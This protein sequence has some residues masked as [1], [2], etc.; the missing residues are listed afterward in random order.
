MTSVLAY[1]LKSAIV[2]ALF[3]GFYWSFLRKETFFR[4]NRY[5]FIG[6]MISSLFLP[7][8][9][10]GTLLPGNE[11][12]PVRTISESYV[13]FQNT[14]I[15][16]EIYSAP[17]E[18][19]Q[20][21]TW[22]A[23]D[24]LLFV[25]VAGAVVLTLRLLTQVT[26]LA[27]RIRRSDPI[28]IDNIKVILHK[29][30]RSP[31]SFFNYVFVN[32][33]QFN[34][35]DM[36]DVLLHEKE[37]IDQKHGFDL[38]FAEL[39]TILQWPNP[40]AWLTKKSLIETHEY[41]AD[42]A[43]LKKGV[44]VDEYQRTLISFMLGAGNPALIT[45]FNF[46][47][48]KKRLIMMKKIK[49][50]NIRK[51]RSL[52]LLPFVAILLIAFS[53]P[54]MPKTSKQSSPLQK[55][56]TTKAM[57]I[58]EQILYIKDG[59]EISY[60]EMKKIPHDSIARVSVLKGDMAAKYGGKGKDGVIIITTKKNA[61]EHHISG[62]VIDAKTGE[63]KQGV[64]VNAYST[65]S[66]PSVSTKTLLLMSTTHKSDSIRK[67]KLPG[68]LLII[69]DGVEIS[70]EE[71]KNTPHDSIARVEVLKG[72]MAAKY[73]GN[74]KDGVIIITTK[75]NAQEHH[76]SG[77]V[78]D[79]KTGEPKKGVSV[80]VYGTTTG[81]LTDKNGK[82]SLNLENEVSKLSFSFVGY[83]TVTGNFRSGEAPVIKLKRSVTVISFDNLPE[84]QTPVK[85]PR[86]DKSKPVFFVVESMPEYPGGVRALRDYI[87][88]NTRY[89]AK[90][91]KRKTEGTVYVNFTVDETGKVK[92][93]YIDKTKTVD[94][95]LDKEAVRVVSQM[96]DWKP[97]A[98][99]GKNVPV[100][101]SVPVTFNL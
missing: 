75:K 9:N 31:F 53:D 70:N 83:E 79:A 56:D 94:P 30:V 97:G 29:K 54:S 84:P 99:R 6:S 36:G 77:T 44:P 18:K 33:E 34:E 85:P 7:L 3:Y 45:P 67:A 5:Y 28:D 38:L 59:T 35:T 1:F 72:D 25:Y 71:M 88:S 47:L 23:G 93:V 22:Q 55:Q 49:S 39:L 26:V 40:F 17:V 43:V 21:M 69:R 16:P 61:Q 4:F 64:S 42:S 91:K 41:L 12:T 96:S 98:Q 92:D 2:L 60:E 19:V 73:G 76:I 63:L 14:V 89:P 80:I 52:I 15:A 95:L 62:I 78:I 50:P 86:I 74:G 32:P 101:L 10:I 87:A 68:Q 8:I 13:S 90:A 58:P 57:N 66:E 51:L 46:S 24:I 20:N 37:H 100:Q 82:F 48:N 11:V 65:I 81:T 27:I